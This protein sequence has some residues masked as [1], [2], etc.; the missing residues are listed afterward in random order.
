MVSVDTFGIIRRTQRSPSHS[1]T[2]HLRKFGMAL[3]GC[4]HLAA[5][6]SVNAGCTANHTTKWWII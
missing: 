5:I 3:E 4:A 2:R 1:F 6:K